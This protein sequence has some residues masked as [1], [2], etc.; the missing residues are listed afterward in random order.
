MARASCSGVRPAH[1]CPSRG[2]LYGKPGRCWVAQIMTPTHSSNSAATSGFLA[3][4]VWPSPAHATCH[5]G[6]RCRG[7]TLV[8]SIR[9]PGC[10]AAASTRGRWL[11]CCPHPVLFSL[12]TWPVS[13]RAAKPG[14]ARIWLRVRLGDC[15]QSTGARKSCSPGQ[16]RNGDWRTVQPFT[17]GYFGCMRLVADPYRGKLR[18]SRHSCIAALPKG[19]RLLGAANWCSLAATPATTRCAA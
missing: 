1:A 5:I 8:S 18:V 12:S 11:Q 17:H 9:Q 7:A 4:S 15:W 14:T 2:G 3:W 16:A 6:L 13:Y 10:A 19:G